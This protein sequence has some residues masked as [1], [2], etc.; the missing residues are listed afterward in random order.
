MPLPNDYVYLDYAATS[1]LLESSVEAMSEVLIPGREGVL[2]GANANSLSSPG[3]L[4]HKQLESARR[5]IA[6]SIGARPNEIVFT[7]G[8]TEADNAAILGIVD[9]LMRRSH[10]TDGELGSYKIITSS[11]EHDAVLLP[12]RR[13]KS[14]GF[15]VVHMKPTRDGFI[16]V[17]AFE[18]EIDEKTLFVSIQFANSEI[19]SI[20][21]IK[22]LSEI[23][24][25]FGA[26]FHTDAVQALGKIPFDVETLGVDALS[27]SAHK[28]GGP[29]GF[30]VLYLKS[31][32]PFTPQML[33][34]GQEMG[35]RSG[36]QNVVAAIGSAAAISDACDSMFEE[37]ERLRKLRDK[38]Y[39]RLYGFDEIT[40]TVDVERGSLDYLP[41][42][43]NVIFNGIES[44]T[45]VLRFDSLGFGVSGGSA[46]SSHSLDPSHVLTSLGI[47]P[48]DALC[49]LRIT[50]GRYT[51][52]E[53][54]DS[55]LEAVPR[56]INWNT[57]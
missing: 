56:V 41:N 47:K 57:I 44:E 48:D 33:G 18:K 39:E 32:T 13:L 37:G 46:C 55:F 53:D 38:L 49:A 9:A 12:I 6:D 28:V 52:E 35:R 16:D 36:T 20:Q 51:S 25:R 31:N 50:M 21:P 45:L 8:A 24:H 30:G 15:D 26:L 23:A 10:L 14:L 40:L 11:I 5:K 27:L 1:P 29:K 19:G 17:D 54:V 34:G 3:R 43:V 22:Q 2:T 7:S 4:A 42:L